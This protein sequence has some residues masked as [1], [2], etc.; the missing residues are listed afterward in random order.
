MQEKYLKKLSTKLGIVLGILTLSSAVVGPYIGLKQTI[1]DEKSAMADR[2]STLELNVNQNF[3]DKPTV[4]QMA[5]DIQEL[6]VM[7]TEIKTIILQD[8]RHR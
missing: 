8:H 2:I 4:Q 5:K 6:K 7:Q 1:A 3:A